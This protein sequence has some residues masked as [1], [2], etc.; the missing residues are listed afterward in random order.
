MGPLDLIAAV[1]NTVAAAWHS[2][3]RRQHAR[4][5]ADRE[6]RPGKR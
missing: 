6:A 1:C 3:E 4:E 2:Y 5:A